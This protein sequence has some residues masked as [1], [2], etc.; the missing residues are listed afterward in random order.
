MSEPLRLRIF[1]FF[2]P[3]LVAKWDEEER[4]LDRLEEISKN[5]G[6]IASDVGPL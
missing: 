4:F 6:R 3:R 1:R 5:V 2:F